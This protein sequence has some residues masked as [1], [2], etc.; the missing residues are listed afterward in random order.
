MYTEK[1]LKVS[2]LADVNLTSYFLSKFVYTFI[3]RSILIIQL[4]RIETA[5]FIS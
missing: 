5:K 4:I 3:Y 2:R 1:L